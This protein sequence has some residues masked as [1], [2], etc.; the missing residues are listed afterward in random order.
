MKKKTV[1]TVHSGML[2]PDIRFA[3]LAELSSFYT[4]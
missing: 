4:Y 1:A 2:E 3:F